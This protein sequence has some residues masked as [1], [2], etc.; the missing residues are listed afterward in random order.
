MCRYIH[1]C[2]K[3]CPYTHSK[4]TPISVCPRAKERQKVV[5]EKGTCD[6]CSRSARKAREKVRAQLVGMGIRRGRNGEGKRKGVENTVA[7]IEGPVG[8]PKMLVKTHIPEDIEI[9][10]LE[11][12]I[13]PAHGDI[14]SHYPLINTR[15]KGRYDGREHQRSSSSDIPAGWC[16]LGLEM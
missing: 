13:D 11:V 4:Y 15:S 3:L 9:V 8:G 16:D 6:A 5:E 14:T 1:V 7:R 10:N 12:S 2:Y